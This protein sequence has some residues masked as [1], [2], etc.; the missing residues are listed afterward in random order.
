MKDEEIPGFAFTED[1]ARSIVPTLQHCVRLLEDTV[2][3]TKAMT[4]DY[5]L[6]PYQK[7]IAGIVLDLGWEVLEQ[8]FY[9]KFPDLR[10]PRS[11]PT[12]PKP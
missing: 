6:L 12:E 7:A 2:A 11:S 5:D 9:K 3:E 10:P 1:Q 8:G 4:T